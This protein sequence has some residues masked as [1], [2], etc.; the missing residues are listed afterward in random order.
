MNLWG[1]IDLSAY[2]GTE[3]R[4]I[5]GKEYICIPRRFNPSITVLDG[6]PTAL[7]RLREHKPDHDGFTY[8][9]IPH[10]PKKVA[11]ALAKGDIVRM[12]QPVG[13]F[14]VLVPPS[15]QPSQGPTPEGAGLSARE[16]AANPVDYS[17]IPL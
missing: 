3:F 17:D 6:H 9:A 4:I 10:I 16:L 8:S 15:N 7:L 12:T 14:R 13:R 5:D 2:F 1:T 11:P